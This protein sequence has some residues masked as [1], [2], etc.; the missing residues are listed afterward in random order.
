MTSY[1]VDLPRVSIVIPNLNRVHYLAKSV[2]SVLNQNYPNL[3]CIVVDGGSTDGSVE[4]LGR[5]EERV[6]VI[7]RPPRGHLDA[8]DVGLRSTSGEIVAWLMPGDIYFSGAI[9]RAVSY[10]H[11][12]PEVDVVYGDC[13]HVDIEGN[14]LKWTPVRDWNLDY[15]VE[16]CDF[17]LPQPAT[18]IRRH[19]LEQVG[20]V[21][22]TIDK[23]D[24][25]LWLRI[26]LVG[27]MKYNPQI[28]AGSLE[29]EDSFSN[30]AGEQM[31]R[32]CVALTRKFFSLPNVPLNLRKRRRRSM[33]NAYVRGVDYAFYSGR[34]WRLIWAYTLMAMV[35]DP[36]NTLEAVK[37]LRAYLSAETRS[38][39]QASG[40]RFVRILNLFL[41]LL[42]NPI[43]VIR[44][45]IKLRRLVQSAFRIRLSRL[46]RSTFR[47]RNVLLLGRP[48]HVEVSGVSFRLVPKG[49]VVADLWSG[50]R[51]ERHEL[52]LILRVL[53]PGMTFFDVG[54]NIGLF[55]VVAATKSSG[56]R[57]YAFEI[58]MWT[59][60]VLQENIRLN[61]LINVQAWRTA[62]GD[63]VGEA[64]LQVN[65]PGK[66]GLNTIG[67]P[68]HPDSQIV[69]RERVPITTIDAFIASHGIDQVDVMKIDVE[70]AELL[71]LRGAREL[72]RN[73]D[74]PLILYEGYSWC[75]A[76]FGYHPVE[77]MWSLKDCGYELFA[78]DS[79][80]GQ[81]TP[82]QLGHGYDAMIVAVKPTHPSFSMFWREA[83]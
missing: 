10:L 20:W 49:A 1:S 13:P 44:G 4:F 62:L 25:E 3:E 60:H 18:F 33:S 36:T 52:E 41:Y 5:Y 67:Q 65:A 74:A 59:F 54:S 83:G 40:N 68:S 17:M 12:H 28:L 14:M 57:V 63:Y 71:V 30:T 47:M 75:T 37:R 34:H 70:G 46:L 8:I 53:Q 9:Q 19:I 80:T 42:L 51:F 16:Y 56:V 79:E 66:D 21:D 82:R 29:H 35:W 23:L 77:I 45:A 11:E 78:L 6:K 81:I 58:C 39:K 61:S 27:T 73:D 38:K 64:T 26:G 7:F 76:G 32:S 22:P 48:I 15:A 2:E 43:P 50:L 72:L 69:S 31:A 55:A 24:H